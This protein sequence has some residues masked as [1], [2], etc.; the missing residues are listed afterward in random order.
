MQHPA[1]EQ[2]ACRIFRPV[3]DDARHARVE[4]FERRSSLKP[5]DR[6]ARHAAPDGVRRVE[7]QPEDRAWRVE[8]LIADRLEHVAHWQQQRLDRESARLIQ[9]DRKSTRLNSSH[10]RSSYAVF[11]LKKKK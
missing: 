11:C 1:R 10:V 7:L 4:Y 3:P 6:F 5:S 8:V 9:R 2:D